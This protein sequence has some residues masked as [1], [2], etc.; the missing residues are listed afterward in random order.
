MVVAAGAVA[1]DLQAAV[2]AEVGQLAFAA[3][4]GAF[5]AGALVAPQR[6]ERPRSLHLLLPPPFEAALEVVAGLGER[7]QLGQQ[8]LQ[9]GP[10]DELLQLRCLGEQGEVGDQD[11]AH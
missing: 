7:F 9:A 3:G 10:I 5:T 4:Q 2:H 1:L 11:G 8:R 6:L